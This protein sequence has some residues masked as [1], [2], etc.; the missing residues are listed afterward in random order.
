MRKFYVIMLQVEYNLIIM[1]SNKNE[2]KK[3]Y[4]I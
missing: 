4:R 2:E 3:I 1:R